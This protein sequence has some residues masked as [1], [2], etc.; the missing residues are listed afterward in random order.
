M[1]QD[2]YFHYKN[3]GRFL[4]IQ[5]AYCSNSYRIPLVKKIIIFFSIKNVVDLDDLRSSNYIF[6]FKMFF[7]RRFFISSY[8][9]RFHL[10]V[11][12]HS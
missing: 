5:K 3:V 11:L 7:G 10:N 6:L 12:Y 8:C 4:L 9:T 2:L 1:T